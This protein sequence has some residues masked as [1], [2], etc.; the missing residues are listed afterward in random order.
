[1]SGLDFLL[2][3]LLVIFVT[4]LAVRAF[5]LTHSPVK[6]R[7]QTKQARVAQSSVWGCKWKRQ[8]YM[9]S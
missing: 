1:M 5:P 7:M 2:P 9:K 3:I 4:F 6:S 8:V